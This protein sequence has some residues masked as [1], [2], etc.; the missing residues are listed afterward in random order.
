MSVFA[1][2][3]SVLHF[4]GVPSTLNILSLA[5]ERNHTPFSSLW[6]VEAAE[7]AGDIPLT[8]RFEG[9]TINKV[10]SNLLR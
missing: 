4:G 6:L 5:S 2:G 8:F 3:L 1:P 9:L 7:D 10:S